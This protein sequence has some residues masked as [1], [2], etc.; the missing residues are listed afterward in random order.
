MKHEKYVVIAIAALIAFV[1]CVVV[2]ELTEESDAATS[3][4]LEAKDVMNSDYRNFY[5]GSVS[6]IYI[7]NSIVVENNV[8]VQYVS[9]ISSFTVSSSNNHVETT[10]TK[11]NYSSGQTIDWDVQYW[12][13]NSEGYTFQYGI[14]YM[15]N[16]GTNAPA[17]QLHSDAYTN[18]NEITLSSSTPTPPTGARF[19]GWS[20]SNSASEPDYTAGETFYMIGEGIYRLYAVYETQ[21][22]YTYNLVYDARG[23]TNAPATQTWT[24]TATSCEFTI[25][26]SR[27]TPPSGSTFY[28]WNDNP[29]YDVPEYVSGDTITL[30]A[31]GS[32]TTITTTM[33][34]IYDL[35]LYTITIN[36]ADPTTGTVSPS[37][38]NNVPKYTYLNYGNL[39]LYV[40]STTVT[41][42]PNPG[43][44]S[45]YWTCNVST[46][47]NLP[48]DVQSDITFTA[49]LANRYYLVIFDNDFSPHGTVSPTSIQSVPYNAP[50]TVNGNSITINGTTVTATPDLGY[51]FSWW[52]CVVPGGGIPST[53]TEDMRFTAYFTDERTF[54]LYYDMNGGTPQIPSDSSITTS[55]TT[56]YDFDISW[57]VPT[58]TG[59]IF[60]GWCASP[61]A[62]VV[63][64]HPGDRITV[65]WAAGGTQ[66]LYAV[67]ELGTSH[68]FNLYYDMKGGAPQIDT[69]TYEGSNVTT[70]HWFRI[71]S[72][73]PTKEG[74]N[75]MGWSINAA[76]TSVDYS[77][78]NQIPV[79]WDVESGTGNRT[80]YAVWEATDAPV[81]LN[82]V[83]WSNDLYNGSV[84]LACRFTGGNMN[85]THL[86]SIPLY[87]GNMTANNQPTWEKTNY[88][89]DISISYPNTIIVITVSNNGAPLS[90]F[91]VTANLG[92]WSGFE[93]QIDAE[94]GVLNF[95]P[96]NRFN[97]FTSYTTYTA[98]EQTIADW[99]E[100]TSDN[101]I[102]RI[103]HKDEGAGTPMSFQ[104]VN[105]MTFLNTFGVVM[106]DPSINVHDY[107]PDYDKVRLNFYSFALYGDSF[108]L[109]GKTFPVTEGSVTI[110]YF[111][112]YSGM[113]HWL[114][115]IDSPTPTN[116]Y[117]ERYVAQSKT[118]MLSNIY[119]TWNGDTCSLTFVND[120]FTVDLGTYSAGDESV[121]FTGFWYFTT[122]LY[123]PVTVTEKSIDESS[124]K[125][126]PDIGGPAMILLYLGVLLGLGLIAH[127]KLGLK[128]LDLTTLAIGMV[129]GFTL[130]G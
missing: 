8:T 74:Y 48:A 66:T 90:G 17:A 80:I 12:D 125:A 111:K 126:M 129:L 103:V 72:V 27:P 57:T 33:Y 121:S 91:P 45:G 28:G 115:S 69:Q 1:G 37:V 23:G 93:L 53:V 61:A 58:K 117:G 101:A 24:G 47:D 63:D 127:V 38:I 88:Q 106:T 76:G 109:N 92:K 104:V 128:W 83:Y 35:P 112:D 81:L 26:S 78:G 15:A 2:Y 67:W 21:T 5:F 62:T 60:Q 110:Y 50:I 87:K 71:S 108:T 40:G 14:V 32:N 56:S 22:V 31:S 114:A 95:T 30:T 65:T 124:W 100:H 3:Y 73:T 97:N 130:L 52:D 20:W 54:Y 64:Y 43:Y 34:A 4:Y 75:F 9:D 84:K 6:Y 7:T 39:E 51:T 105:T 18:V 13:Y 55:T 94:K 98:R 116:P 82:G 79:A 118:M 29:N 11:S 119:V 16:G 89:V 122:T 36:V 123:E 41:V 77:P 102:Y 85:A 19:L 59:Y 99:S 96:M 46:P 49:H 10:I 68:V 107:F 86:I 113:N 25:T 70:S 42:T 44:K 120:K